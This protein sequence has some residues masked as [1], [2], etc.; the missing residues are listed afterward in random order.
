M[1]KSKK[2]LKDI[3]NIFFNDLPI[4]IICLAFA[5][6]IFMFYRRSTLGK[7]YFSAP[8]KIENTNEL[9]AASSYPRS[10]KVTLWGDAL[11]I[12]SID[13]ADIEVYLDLNS[14]QGAGNFKVPIKTRINGSALNV[15][16]LD[17]T[18][19]PKMVE[20]R[21][22]ESA[23][24]RVPV[25]LS[26]K[27]SSAANYEISQT[28]IDPTSVEARGPKSLIEKIE[29]ISTEAILLEN[30]N[31]SFSGTANLLKTDPLVTI[32][33]SG[34]VDYWVQIVEKIINKD[35]KNLQV[36][37][38]NLSDELVVTSK[39][40]NVLVTLLGTE[41]ILDAFS[42]TS[43]FVSLNCEEIT[44]PG[45]YNLKVDLNIPEGLTVKTIFPDTIA[46]Q[47]DIKQDDDKTEEGAPEKLE[48][49][50]KT[51]KAAPKELENQ[52]Q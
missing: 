49:N 20:L 16:P 50:N 32:A 3:F 34:K 7:R 45:E 18:I 48:G 25:Y 8:L 14:Y 33:G 36:S 23:S 47:I 28:V 38:K 4:K 44:E 13:E 35:F 10:V 22:E 43:D 41:K 21:L 29:H 30:R 15:E 6:I 51:E 9:V 39:P 46:V 11:N 37:F 40:A 24:K 1:S 52:P 12:A 26:L 19:E 42:P 17:I 27:G 31:T 5:F 2:N